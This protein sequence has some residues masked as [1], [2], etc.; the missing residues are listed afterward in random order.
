MENNNVNKWDKEQKWEV[1]I[2]PY[3]QE[4]PIAIPEG[5]EPFALDPQG[6]IQIR[7]RIK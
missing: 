1:A 3:K 7:R 2:A 4:L 5:W 6:N